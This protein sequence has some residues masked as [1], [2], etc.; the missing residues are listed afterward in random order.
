[1]PYPPPVLNL[2]RAHKG[3]ASRRPKGLA[4]RRPKGL[5]SRRNNPLFY[6]LVK[7]RIKLEH[8]LCAVYICVTVVGFLCLVRAFCS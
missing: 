3:L 2:N 7:H 5:A 6:T 8:D 4:S 1:M